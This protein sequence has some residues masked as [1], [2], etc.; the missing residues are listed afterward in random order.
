V[1]V[2]APPPSPRHDE[3]E[4]LIREARARQR[5]RRL[6][7]AGAVAVLAAAGLSVWAAL[8]GGGKGAAGPR[9][10]GA[11]RAVRGIDDTGRVQISKVGTSGGVTW[12]INGRGMWLTTNGGRT[13]RASTPPH[14]R[15]VVDL[16]DEVQQ[17]EFVDAH[18]GW[19]ISATID[20]TSD[21]GRSWRRSV[22]YKGSCCGYASFLTGRLG[23][24]TASTEL[25]A[26]RDGGSTWKPAGLVGFPWA[27]PTFLTARRGVAVGVGQSK[28]VFLT[29]DGGRHWSARRLPGLANPQSL[30]LPSLAVFGRRLVALTERLVPAPRL[31]A[32][33]S[34]DGGDRWVARPLP[35][36]WTPVIGNYDEQR[37]SAPS[38][39]DWFAAARR[40]LVATTDA[41]RSWRR[42]PVA[43]LP[44]GWQITAIDFTNPRTGWAVFSRLRKS[45]LVRTT[46]G[47]RDWMPAGPRRQKR[48]KHG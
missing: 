24:M 45:V 9:R 16:T 33:A 7:G 10:D 8:P 11:A 12:A 20:R 48:R 46:D 4:A 23:Y 39:T 3:L 22:P 30:L 28:S 18:H 27:F 34:A 44:H 17:V 19:V 31:V 42:V 15:G 6:I 1:S 40:S 43:D 38:A 35:R 14:L 37:F 47:G 36:W 29:T 41:G 2:I 13:W 32:Y 5:R 25:L 26:T 21:G